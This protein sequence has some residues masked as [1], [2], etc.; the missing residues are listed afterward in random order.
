M[1]MRDYI[2][3]WLGGSRTAPAV[4]NAS[5]LPVV[6][7]D[8]NYRE[9]FGPAINLPV[10][11]EQTALMVSAVHACV[12]L[13][14]G[15]ISALPLELYHQSV[16]GERERLTNDNLW[17]ILNEEFIP[18]WSA[19]NAWEYMTQSLLL[20]G[21]AFAVIER[22]YAGGVRGL[23]PVHP[24]RASVILAPD[25]RRLVYSILPELPADGAK[26]TIY[27]Q[28]DIL[29]IGG[30]GF[31]GFRGLSPIRYALRMTG[32]VTIATQEYSANFFANSARPD[33]AITSP[34]KLSPE[35]VDQLRAMLNDRH[36]GT[37]KAHQPMVLSGGLDVKQM[38]MPI[39]D[40]QLIETRKFQVE[41]IAR[42]YGVPAFMIGHVEKT[43]SWGS[44]VAE[45]GTAF[46][47][48]T[49]AQHL[50]KFETEINRKLFRTR[51][52]VAKF[53]T[54]NLERADMT[55][56][57]NSFRVGLGR[58]GEPGFL[59]VAEVRQALNLKR[60]PDGEL[61]SGIAAPAAPTPAPAPAE[62]PTEPAEPPAPKPA[63]KKGKKS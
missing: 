38:Q 30:F 19:A 4:Q 34:N 60:Q 59:T 21:D 26:A 33:F 58:A 9:I 37:S 13:I 52:K 22:D 40:M 8:S 49:L 1:S 44:G 47:R 62:D 16:D 12:N 42:I 48:Y 25:K 56:L 54:A 27:D 15:T 32:A 7:Q 63:P 10:P 43:T 39:G 20:H 5:P 17:W 51:A 53:D 11:T 55:T 6:L 45:M 46:V 29:H 36:G 14:A 18:R 57:F 61:F 3:A 35:T 50:N 2:P 24:M 31:D 41:E 28:D 23:I